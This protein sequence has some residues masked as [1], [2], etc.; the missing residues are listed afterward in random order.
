MASF[1]MIEFKMSNDN[2]KRKW[3]PNFH[4]DWTIIVWTIALI[5]CCFLAYNAYLYFIISSDNYFIIESSS[6]ITP[7]KKIRQKDLND[8]IAEFQIKKEKFNTI[9]NNPVLVRDPSLSVSGEVPKINNASSTTLI[10]PTK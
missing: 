1:S 3:L 2:D 6:I 8:V 7:T 9:I 10:V 5:I 4:R